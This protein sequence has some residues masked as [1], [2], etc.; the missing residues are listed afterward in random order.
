M[1]EVTCIECGDK[2]DK[3]TGDMDV[4][5]CLTCIL[6]AQDPDVIKS[7]NVSYAEDIDQQ[8]FAQGRQSSITDVHNEKDVDVLEKIADEVYSRIEKEEIRPVTYDNVILTGMDNKSYVQLEKKIRDNYL[9]VNDRINELLERI[10][11][12]EKEVRE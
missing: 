4:R 1:I 10:V 6:K 9:L 7:D 8:A 5:M 2:F 11:A 3:Y 12:I